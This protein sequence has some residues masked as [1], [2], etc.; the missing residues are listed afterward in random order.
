MQR[1]VENGASDTPATGPLLL[2]P[3][4]PPGVTTLAL[5]AR[6]LSDP[7][8]APK[9]NPGLPASPGK[10]LQL[11]TV[12]DG[13]SPERVEEESDRSDLHTEQ[14]LRVP[15]GENTG[16]KEEEKLVQ[17]P[18]QS[19]RG[20][21]TRAGREGTCWEVGMRGAGVREAARTAPGV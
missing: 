21:R 2:S 20:Q 3:A 18:P 14:S 11:R 9:L 17:R 10:E 8:E 16:G 15:C 6:V 1:G 5:L 12:A 4:S 7:P 19:T 13:A